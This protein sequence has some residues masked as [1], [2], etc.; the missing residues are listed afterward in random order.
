VRG[1]G[2]VQMARNSKGDDFAKQVLE[3]R[4]DLERQLEEQAP[5]SGVR[6]RRIAGLHDESTRTVDAGL[7]RLHRKRAA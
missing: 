2:Y 4:A 3:K 6:P 5:P 7:S 1:E